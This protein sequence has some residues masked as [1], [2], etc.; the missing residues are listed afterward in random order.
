MR[1]SLPVC[2]LVLSVATTAQAQDVSGDWEVI[3]QPETKTVFAYVPMTSGLTIGFRCVDGAYG[4]IIAGLPAAGP[5]DQVRTLTISIRGETPR[6]SQ[7]TV[8][9]D[10]TAAIADYPAPLARALREGGAVTVVVPGGAGDGRNLRHDLTLPASTAAIDET[11]NACDRPLVDPRDARL[12]EITANGLSAGVNWKV[13]P[14]PRY[15]VTRYSEGY[16]VV[17][18][19][20]QPDGK[21]DD[22]LVESEFPLGAGFGSNAL[23]ALPRARIDSPGETLGQYAPRMIGFRVRYVRP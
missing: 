18:C 3:R 19:V 7:W 2:A 20:V 9:T 21:V 5:D 8:T 14:R 13:P 23:R 4:A 17:S 15:P 11:L 12:P 10:P 22:C 6:G 1:L 16:A